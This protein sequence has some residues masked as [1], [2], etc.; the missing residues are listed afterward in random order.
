MTQ[1]IL[2][3]NIELRASIRSLFDIYSV[4][5]EP[6]GR[7]IPLLAK[8]PIIAGYVQSLSFKYDW[9]HPYD[10][11][12]I[13]ES[14]KKTYLLGNLSFDGPKRS[15][16]EM[17]SQCWPKLSLITEE[18]KYWSIHV[19]TAAFLSLL[20]NLKALK[21]NGHFDSK[22]FNVLQLDRYSEESDCFRSLTEIFLDWT[23]DIDCRKS[24][25]RRK[26]HVFN[27]LQLFLLPSVH[28]LYLKLALDSEHEQTVSRSIP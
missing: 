13:E 10:R 8:S 24:L 20:P 5:R 18:I 17:L 26:F 22:F 6:I 19:R 14:K 28:T 11:F 7:L 21:I 25:F 9:R 3:R 23:F 2:W 27:V 15:V 12:Y 16:S 4:P 1:P